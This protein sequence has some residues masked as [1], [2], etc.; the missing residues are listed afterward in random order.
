MDDA[1]NYEM[2]AGCVAGAVQKEEY[3]AIIINAGFKNVSIKKEKEVFLPD[4]VLG[5]YFS[6]EEISN[7]RKSDVGIYSITVYAEK[8]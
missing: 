1:N 5:N 4:E 2:Y 7:F 8:A 6:D 3:L